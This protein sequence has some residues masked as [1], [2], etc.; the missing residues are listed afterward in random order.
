MQ[1]IKK[2]KTFLII[3]FFICLLP[4]AVSGCAQKS[5]VLTIP[6]AKKLI[7]RKIKFSFFFA[8]PY[9]KAISL[10]NDKL[11]MVLM[12]NGYIKFNKKLGY[13]S[14]T[15]LFKPY[16]FKKSDRTYVRMGKFDITSLHKIQFISRKKAK[17]LFS[18]QFKPNVIYNLMIANN[19]H[20][21]LFK[22]FHAKKL[23]VIFKYKPFLEWEV[24]KFVLK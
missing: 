5:E 12:K 4:L 15:S 2:I 23:G 19:I 16:L 20:I 8:V 24:D 13:T 7:L 1:T 6:L 10:N 3:I 21:K 9:E 22:I 11:Y 18:F 17:I 14:F